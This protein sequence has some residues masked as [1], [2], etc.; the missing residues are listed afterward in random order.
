M[1]ILSL[2]KQDT[3]DGKNYIDKYIIYRIDKTKNMLIVLEY[4]KA[5]EKN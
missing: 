5:I 1:I 4:Y 2:I 3:V